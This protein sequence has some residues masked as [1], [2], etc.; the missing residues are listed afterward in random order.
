MVFE[1]IHGLKSNLAFHRHGV[2]FATLVVEGQYSEVRDGVPGFYRA[3]SVVIH[4]ALEEHA[5]FFSNAAR[6]LNVELPSDLGLRPLHVSDDES[7]ARCVAAIVRT[8]YRSN[9]GDALGDAV[10][11]FE[12]K[13]FERRRRLLAAKPQ[14][15]VETLAAFDWIE[16]VPLREAARL[17]G[18]HPTHFARA[19]VRFVG[20]TPNEYRREVRMRRAAALLLRSTE[21]LARVALACGF[22]DQSHFSNAFRATAGLSPSA[23][24]GVFAR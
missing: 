24:Q 4:A 1:T 23:F 7:T 12:R 11:Q 2:P 18:V 10:A 13:L 15:L 9:A 19:F 5:D 8:F 21:S 14:W 3:G 20:M 22:G 17:A 6:C 16:P